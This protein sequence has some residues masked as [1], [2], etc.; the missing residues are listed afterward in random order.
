MMNFQTLS[1]LITLIA[2]SGCGTM[3]NKSSVEFLSP[4]AVSAENTGIIVLSVG[5]PQHCVSTATFL[6]LHEATTRQPVPRVPT[7]GVDAY[8]HKSD[9]ANHH[10]TLNALELLPGNYYFT[11]V[12]ANPYIRMV[13]TP[14]FEFDVKAG[15]TK[16]IG[17]LYMTK[18]CG[19]STKFQV[20]DQFTRDMRLVAQKNPPLA[21]RN[22]SRQLLRSNSAIRQD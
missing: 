16:Y 14:K 4:L 1:I 2:L 15:E 18:S 20:R 22:I 3:S 21:E 19:L 12:I 11:P 9:F 17:E 7:I 8:V 10:G 13:S 6:S 5:A